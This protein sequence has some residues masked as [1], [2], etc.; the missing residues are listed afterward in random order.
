MYG[1]DH[2]SIAL[3]L[4]PPGAAGGPTPEAMALSLSQWRAMAAAAATATACVAAA[5]YVAGASAERKRQAAAPA[6]RALVAGLLPGR[7]L[8]VTGGSSGIGR[9]IA[10]S[11]AE[12]GAKVLILDVT[13]EPVE[14]GEPTVVV[15][16]Q[17]LRS[18]AGGGEVAL[19]LGD[20]TKAADIEAAVAEAVRRWGRLDV[21]INNAAIGVG[22]DLLNTT[23]QD[24]NRV[25]DINAKGY[26]MGSRAAARQMLSQ[27]PVARDGVRGKII[28]ISSQHGMVC[29]PGDIAY[30]VSK[31][32]AVYM[33][34]QI[35]AEFAERGIVCNAVA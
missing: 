18:S 11:A 4:Q 3:L 15:A 26:W 22:G 35:A 1:C 29:C 5:A 32:A 23:E 2:H 34:R 14:G 6:T 13:S 21:W 16:A 8:V 12:N 33:T 7:V 9:E 25:L 31:A 30:G 19:L 28:N 20:T 27:P 24:W 17:R 10:L